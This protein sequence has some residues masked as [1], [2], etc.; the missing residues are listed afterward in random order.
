MGSKVKALLGG[1]RCQRLLQQLLQLSVVETFGNTEL[2]QLLEQA[3][4]EVAA[5]KGIDL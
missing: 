2:K 4:A 5:Q 3:L 1:N